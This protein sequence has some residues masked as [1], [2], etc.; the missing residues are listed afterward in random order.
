MFCVQESTW[1]LWISL[2]YRNDNYRDDN[3]YR[4]NDDDYRDNSEDYRDD[5]DDYRNDEDNYRDDDDDYRNDVDDNRDDEDN[6]RDDDDYR[7]F[8]SEIILRHSEFGRGSFL[9][10]LLDYPY[11]FWL[12]FFCRSSITP[13]TIVAC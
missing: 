10:L 3:D 1:Q 9:W 6:Y 5:D 4:D 13:D 8:F 12:V 11:I 7:N 2:D